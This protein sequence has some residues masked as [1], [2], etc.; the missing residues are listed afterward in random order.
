MKNILAAFM[1]FT[2]LPFWRIVTVEKEYF[3]NVVTWWPYAGIITGGIGAGVMFGASFIFP[4]TVAVILGVAARV[5]VTGALHE[6]GLAD[7]FD[8]F[9]GGRDK[10]SIL[11]IMK[12][13]H[14]GSYGVL[15]L[16][17]YFALLIAILSALP[18]KVAALLF[19]CGDITCKSI[20]SGIVNLLPYARPEQES[21][22]KLVY[23]K[24]QGV[25]TV[26]NGALVMLMLWGVYA[27]ILPVDAAY[28]IVMPMG[29]F[30]ALIHYMRYK[31]QGYTGDCCGATF[32]LCELSFLL[33]SLGILYCL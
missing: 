26:I 12:D 30:I 1:F 7:F 23:N 4:A 27:N 28:A 18:V 3:K 5:L 24:S 16:V 17:L 2:R 20:A 29:V 14:I 10:E 9:G 19:F 13:S 31:I 25:A 15:G 22:N 32:L 21:K 6:D 8:G 11:R 33:A